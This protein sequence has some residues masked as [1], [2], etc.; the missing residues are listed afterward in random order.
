M[1][2]SVELA[3]AAVCRILERHEDMTGDEAMRRDLARCRA[4]L[5]VVGEQFDRSV[6]DRLTMLARYEALVGPAA[7]GGPEGVPAL[8]E[9]SS[10]WSWEHF[11]PSYLE[12]CLDLQRRA[13]VAVLEQAGPQSGKAVAELR[14]LLY[15]DV[16]RQVLMD[17]TW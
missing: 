1:T 5:T 7:P 3:L 17:P 6:T 9:L 15:E 4:V 8:A 11:R 13:A 2:P 10:R 16:S 12:Q 14:A